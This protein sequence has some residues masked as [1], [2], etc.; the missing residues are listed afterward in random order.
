VETYP[1]DKNKDVAMGHPTHLRRLVDAIVA[2]DLA[3][4]TQLIRDLPGMAVAQFQEGAS[5]QSA[6]DFFLPQAQSYIYVGDTALHLAAA[7]YRTAIARALIDA[8]ANVRARNRH[9]AEPLHSGAVGQP[10]GG[11]WNPAAQAEMIALLIQS[12]AEPNA[13]DKHGVTPLHRAVRTRCAA[14]VRALLENGADPAQ[15]NGSGSTPMALAT[16]NTGRGGSGSAAAKAEQ[17]EIL[18]LL[19]ERLAAA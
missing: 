10:G 6:Q 4:S 2:G 5:R 8:G 11:N 17:K 16:M 19:E 13:V 3:L 9:G 12:G 14:A 1:S 7:M 18:R 15:K